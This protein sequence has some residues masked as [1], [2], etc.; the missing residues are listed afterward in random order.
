MPKV[1]FLPDG[2]TV[3]V[4]RGTSILDAA[5]AADV[6][7]PLHGELTFKTAR[8]VDVSAHVRFESAERVSVSARFPVS[9]EAHGIERPSLLFVKV[10]ENVELDVQLLLKRP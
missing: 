7:L 10:D 4:P 5:E 9:L 2:K 3:E 1:T 8:P 6:D